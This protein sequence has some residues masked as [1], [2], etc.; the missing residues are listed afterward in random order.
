LVGTSREK[1]FVS[2]EVLLQGAFQP[3]EDHD[4]VPIGRQLCG[5][6]SHDVRVHTPLERLYF[7]G[8]K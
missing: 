4:W 2:F 5:D 3:F 1:A 7:P 8:E 6:E